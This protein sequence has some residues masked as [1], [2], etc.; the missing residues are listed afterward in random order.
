V[1]LSNLAKY[2]MT[3]SV[4]RSLCDSWASCTRDCHTPVLRYALS[5]ARRYKAVRYSKIR[6][7]PVILHQ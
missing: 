3:R 5:A 2:S 7:R 1:I 6:T 4:A